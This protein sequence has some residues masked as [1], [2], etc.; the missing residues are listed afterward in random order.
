[1]R[2]GVN[3]FR[4]GLSAG[5]MGEKILTCLNRDQENRD[6]IARIARDFDWVSVTSQVESYYRDLL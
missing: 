5:E 1:V 4:S 3:G 6:L 2:D